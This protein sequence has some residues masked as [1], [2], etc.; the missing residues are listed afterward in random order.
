M[1]F[2]IKNEKDFAYYFNNKKICN[3]P[4]NGQE[5]IYKIFNEVDSESYIESWISKYFEKADIKIKIN[6]I[7]KGISIKTGQNCSMHQESIKTFDKFLL[8]IGK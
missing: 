7:V 4:I 3:L 5:L 1:Q 2:G 8:S 6:G